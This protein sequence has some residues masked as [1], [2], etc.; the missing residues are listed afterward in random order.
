MVNLKRQ[1]IDHNTTCLYYVQCV[2][3]VYAMCYVYRMI[4]D[5]KKKLSWS[6]H[7]EDQIVQGNKKR[8]N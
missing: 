8:P 6:M 3:Y 5:D 7:L 2:L 1:S 4:K